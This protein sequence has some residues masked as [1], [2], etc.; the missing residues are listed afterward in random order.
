MGC[1]PG[2][3]YA[4]TGAALLRRAAAKIRE[5][6]ENAGHPWEWY[7]ADDLAGHNGWSSDG[8]PGAMYEPFP[9][10]ALWSPDVALAVADV[11]EERARR[12]DAIPKGFLAAGAAA[13][14]LAPQEVALARLILKEDS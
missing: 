14:K 2:P 3:S 13:E 9:H 10:M 11:L 12:V 5:T 6:A 1:D 4:D 8:I 7:T